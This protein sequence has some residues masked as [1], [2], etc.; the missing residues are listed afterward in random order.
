MSGGGALVHVPLVQE[1]G[2]ELTLSMDWNNARVDVPARVVRCV[3]QPVELES[4]TLRR[5]EYHV[6][7]EFLPL[8]RGQKE[9]I[10]EI[11]GAAERF[12][13]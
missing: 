13:I 6:A 8:N 4:A 5:K 10:Q 1:F 12:E 9:K 11:L 3:E 7:L 2:K